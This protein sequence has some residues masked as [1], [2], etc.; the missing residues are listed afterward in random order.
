VRV[1]DLDW[2][3]DLFI[4][5]TVPRWDRAA[6]LARPGPGLWRDMLNAWVPDGYFPL[7]VS[8]RE[9]PRATL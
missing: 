3:K 4:D 1:P 8:A 7:P 9:R 5:V 6:I 2:P